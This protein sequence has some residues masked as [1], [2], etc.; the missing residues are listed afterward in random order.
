VF[1]AATAASGETYG[2]YGSVNSPNGWAGYFSGRGYFSSSVGIGTTSPAAPLDIRGGN[3]DTASTEGDLRIGS[4]SHRLKLGISTDG[5]G[6]GHATITAQGGVNA[7]SL[8]AG[9]TLATQRTLTILGTGQVGI[10]TATPIYRLHVEDG[11]SPGRA[12]YG[13][14]TA[15]SGVAT[16]VWGQSASSS[17][18][19]VMG[20][21]TATNGE[22]YGGYFSSAS[23]SGTGVYGRA[24]ATSG[25]T[26]GVLG[27]SLSPAGYG[28]YSQGA[29]AATGTKS[30]QMDHPLSP[31]T[32][33][34]NH[35]CTE[36][37]EPMNTYSGN[38]VTD[39]QGYATITLP[40]YFESIN[41]DCRYQLTV[42]DDSDD[43]VLAKVVREIQNNQFV[44]RTSKPF[45]KVSWRVEAVRNDL[46]M[47]HYGYQT[48]QEKPKEHQGKYLH[49]E[50]YGQ[51]KERGIHYRPEP[52]PA[53]N[54]T[55]KP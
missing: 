54:E 14:A 12:L 52:E 43:F 44:I 25:V 1:G 29:F 47:Q 27:Q 51:P 35:F 11:S 5:G 18:R 31:E 38:V 42:I 6:A 2:V 20:W 34:L 53:P 48:E 7:L 45:V 30:F 28:V 33:Y 49:P 23:T 50:L 40:A 46:W 37:P 55:I 36:S 39:A 32:H 21:A 8:G 41:R 4:A 26:Y 3:W 9:T 16:G 13:I 17:G 10:G 19:G 22:N 15:T 24:T